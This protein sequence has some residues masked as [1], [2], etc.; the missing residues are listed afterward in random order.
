MAQLKK[1]ILRFSKLILCYS[2]SRVVRT[3]LLHKTLSSYFCILLKI[4]K[5]IGNKTISFVDETLVPKKK[6]RFSAQSV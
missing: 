1:L 6:R 3:N 2:K 5:S 4:K